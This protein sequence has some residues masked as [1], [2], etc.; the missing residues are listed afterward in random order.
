MTDTPNTVETA[1]ADAE[2]ERKTKEAYFTAGQYALMWHQTLHFRRSV[3][4][5]LLVMTVLGQLRT[6]RPS[7]QL[8]RIWYSTYSSSESS[9]CRLSSL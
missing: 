9:A 6:A 3:N 4:F 5:H 2:L 7:S 1:T 8:G